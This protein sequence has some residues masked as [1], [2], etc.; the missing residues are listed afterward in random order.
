VRTSTD[1]PTDGEGDD[2]EPAER[3]GDAMGDEAESPSEDYPSDDDA[4]APPA[5]VSGGVDCGQSSDQQ[6]HVLP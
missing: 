5:A 1:E 6:G 2:S 3:T 4:S